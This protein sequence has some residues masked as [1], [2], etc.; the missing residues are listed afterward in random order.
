MYI[1]SILGIPDRT[2][3]F[4]GPGMLCRDFIK[5]LLEEH[6]SNA[7]AALRIPREGQQEILKVIRLLLTSNLG[8]S[9]RKI[10]GTRSQIALSVEECVCVCV[11][12]QRIYIFYKSHFTV[13]RD[14]SAHVK[15][16]SIGVLYGVTSACVYYN[17]VSYTLVISYMYNRVLLSFYIR[18]FFF[19]SSHIPHLC[20]RHF[21]SLMYGVEL[22]R[23]SVD[24]LRREERERERVEIRKH[25]VLKLHRQAVGRFVSAQSANLVYGPATFVSE[26]ETPAI[27]S[28]RKQ[29]A[30]AR[31]ELFPRHSPRL[32]TRN[33]LLADGK[34]R[35]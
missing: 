18:F 1:V 22:N 16:T 3:L 10:H 17:N 21:T 30:R 25:S 29:R 26:A 12:V 7:V 13:Q 8:I 5:V 6:I 11:C 24:Y 14:I 34:G 32:K 27:R 23:T 4:R 2:P 31:A 19:S 33:Y 20:T 35:R 9:R 28:A 15:I